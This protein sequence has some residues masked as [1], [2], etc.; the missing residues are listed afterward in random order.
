[1]AKNP[2][3]IFDRLIERNPGV[4][5]DDLIDAFVDY[6]RTDSE[7]TRKIIEES[8]ASVFPILKKEADGEPL[9]RSEQALLKM[10]S[11]QSVSE[12]ERTLAADCYASNVA[13]P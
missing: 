10:F 12:S 7:I 9:T 4:D 5:K 11:G 3:Q 6:A 1:M 13:K 8:V 2:Q